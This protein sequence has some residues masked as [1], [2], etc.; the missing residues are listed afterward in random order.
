MRKKISSIKKFVPMRD[1][2]GRDEKLLLIKVVAVF[3][4]NF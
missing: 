3:F 1:Y 4:W 2:R